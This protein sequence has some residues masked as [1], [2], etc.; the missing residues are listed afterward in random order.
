MKNA[1]VLVSGLDSIALS[2]YVKYKLK[3]ENIKFLFFDYGQRALK[4]EEYCCREIAK[5]LDVEFKKI[6][7]KWLKDISTAYLNKDEEI[8]ET[9]EKD[10][11]DGRKEIINWWVPCRNSIFILNALAHAEFE[12]LKNKERYDVFIGVKDEGSEHM[13]DTTEK[14]I[15]KI[16]E[17][18]EE[19][20]NDGGYKILA[21]F[22]K[23]DKTKII[24]LGEEL[25]V[26]FELTYSCYIENGFENDKPIHCGKCLN[27]AIRKKAF[28]WSDVEDKSLYK[29]N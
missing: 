14:F 20:T 18:S 24:K 23:M 9:K 5:K 27:C 25:K 3:Y 7:I 6:E 21:P 12:F 17:L 26:P 4:E 29:S 11:E 2:Y 19:A 1:V 13:K 8:P 28:Y 15:E 10:L 22:I 16:N